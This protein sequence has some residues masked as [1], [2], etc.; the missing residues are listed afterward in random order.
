VIRTVGSLSEECGG[1]DEMNRP[2]DVTASVGA[3]GA[4]VFDAH[5]N[6]IAAVSVGGMLKTLL[7]NEAELSAAVRKAAADISARLGYHTN[8]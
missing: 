7:Q 3:F 2:E 6:A 8:P 1:L 4:A 5:G